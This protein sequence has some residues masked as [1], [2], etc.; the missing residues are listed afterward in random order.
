MLDFLPVQGWDS[1][2]HNYRIYWTLKVGLLIKWV[3]GIYAMYSSVSKGARPLKM[4]R[5]GFEQ[6]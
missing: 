5:G 3:N 1:G 4:A 2:E 6:I